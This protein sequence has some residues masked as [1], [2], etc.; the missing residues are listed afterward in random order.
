M[1][2]LPLIE[3]GNREQPWGSVLV[4]LVVPDTYYF[5]IPAE[6]EH[7]PPILTRI[8]QRWQDIFESGWFLKTLANRILLVRMVIAT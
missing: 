2:C 5:V 1:P 8:N 3:G 7:R 6:P 4:D